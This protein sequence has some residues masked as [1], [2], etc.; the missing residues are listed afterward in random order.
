MYTA[1]YSWYSLICSGSGSTSTTTT[2]YT[3]LCSAVY[4]SNHTCL[5]NFQLCQELWNHLRFRLDLKRAW[6]SPARIA[7]Q[8]LLDQSISKV[9][10]LTWPLYPV[11]QLLGHC[12]RLYVQIQA[13]QLVSFLP[14]FM[15]SS[16]WQTVCHDRHWFRTSCDLRDDYLTPKSGFQRSNSLDNC[17]T[18]PAAGAV[19]L[20]PDANRSYVI[21]PD[22]HWKSSEPSHTTWQRQ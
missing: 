13:S 14:E 12:R 15:E 1:L 16:F 22:F 2:N 8:Y 11:Q 9:I 5:F 18:D 17:W 21:H 6:R 20:L 3:L 4:Y 19:A 10:V 7:R